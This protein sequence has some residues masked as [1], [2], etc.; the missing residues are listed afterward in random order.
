MRARRQ[1]F[2]LTLGIGVAVGSPALAPAPVSAGVCGPVQPVIVPAGMPNPALPIP[3]NA[4]VL[5]FFPGPEA[6]VYSTPLRFTA[7][8]TKVRFDAL[9]IAFRD[10]AKRLVP[11]TTVE[12]A[13]TTLPTLAVRPQA[14]LVAHT[15]YQLVARANNREFVLA[16][17]RTGAGP[18]TE[19]PKAAEVEQPLYYTDYPCVSGA[20]TPFAEL[21]LRNVAAPWT[22][23]YEIHV[24]GA[25][26]EVHPGTLRT[27]VQERYDGP[28]RRIYLGGASNGCWPQPDFSFPSAGKLLLGIRPVDLAG[29][30]GPLVRVTLDL[31]HPLHTLSK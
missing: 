11:G 9:T 15:K 1:C 20:C 5:V 4:R 6:T 23:L 3:T 26:G 27:I 16:E 30:Q 31:D 28:T 8:A 7:T 13:G 29:N 14:P 2:G 24:L 10:P 18:I 25:D 17:L 12:M 21:R 19:A 22:T